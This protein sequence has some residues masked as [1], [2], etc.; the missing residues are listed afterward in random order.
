MNK[1]NYLIEVEKRLTRIFMAS[2]ERY[3]IS[4]VER[5]RLEGFMSAGVFMGLV[6]NTMLAKLMNEIHVN[7]FGKTIQQRK[8][9]LPGSWQ[10]MSKYVA[11]DFETANNSRSSACSVGLVTVTGSQI[12]SEDVFLIRPPSKQFLFSD[13]HGLTWDDVKN[14]KTFYEL[15]PS[16]EKIMRGADYLVAHNA[17]FDKG[18]L[19][20]CC[21][22][23]GIAT[24]ALP[25][26][27]TV[28]LARSQWGIN[29]TKLNNVCDALDIPLNHHEAL[30]D[31]RACAKVVMIAESEGWK[32]PGAY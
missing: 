6:T 16:L 5:H 30:S 23:Y 2:K 7:I 8:A 14:E 32:Y 29:P 28:K 25:F 12:S 4:P 3:K 18:V 26:V 20:M 17:T 21:Q 19:N 27:C 10:V 11:I 31:A 22:E 9:E 24:P 1:D 13:I 15:W